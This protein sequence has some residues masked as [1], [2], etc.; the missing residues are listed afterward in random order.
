MTIKSQK[1]NFFKFGTLLGLKDSSPFH[2]FLELVCR[3]EAPLSLSL[4]PIIIY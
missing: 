4:I 3:N 1:Q 2:S